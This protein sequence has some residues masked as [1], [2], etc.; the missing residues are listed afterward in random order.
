MPREVVHFDDA[1]AGPQMYNVAHALGDFVAVK[2]DGTPAYQL[3]TVV[4]DAA[5]GVMQVVRG[6]DLLDSTPRQILLYRALSVAAI[7]TYTHLP[8]V[9]GLDGRRLAKR[10]GDS[11]V[12]AYRAAGV[13][14]PRMLAWLAR[15][16]GIVVPD[17]SFVAPG[18]IDHFRLSAVSKSVIVFDGDLCSGG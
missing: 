11:R 9:V 17:V 13:T 3:A 4:D 6:D 10:H 16:L 5:A 14:T 1:F 18:L 8:L 7:P 2:P 12:S 15:S